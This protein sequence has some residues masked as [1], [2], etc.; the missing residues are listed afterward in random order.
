MSILYFDDYF[1]KVDQVILL[2]R[3]GGEAVC[4][5]MECVLIRGLDR[6]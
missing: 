1:Q 2:E 5:H 4:A 6:S 3:G